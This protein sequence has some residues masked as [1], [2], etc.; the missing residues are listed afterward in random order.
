MPLCNTP[1]KA[2]YYALKFLCISGDDHNKLI[3]SDSVDISILSKTFP[4]TI[5]RC[6]YK[7]IACSMSKRI[8]YMFQ[9]IKIHGNIYPFLAEIKVVYP[10]FVC[11]SV[12]ASCK[13]ICV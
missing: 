7:F 9:V 8:I 5:G 6:T 12:K 3:S 10:F 4:H 11:M 2:F 1:V 13:F